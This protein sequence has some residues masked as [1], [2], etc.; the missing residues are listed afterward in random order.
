VL[1]REEDAALPSLYDG[2]VNALDRDGVDVR[3]D[4]K[5]GRVLGE[6]RVGTSQDADELWV[7]TQESWRVP[8]LQ[9]RGG[10]VIARTSPLPADE[11][12]L[13]TRLQQRIGGQL[14]EAG[15][16]DLVT[17]LESPR[18]AFA[19]ADVP[20][21]DQGDARLLGRLN[22]KVQHSVIDCRCAIVAFPS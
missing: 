5:W 16:K 8:D 4:P 9:A 12:V 21:V 6:H 14:A 1:V 18:A 15:R 11:D 13:V 7:V 3:V 2:V 10:R 22:A 20:G 19:L 17:Y